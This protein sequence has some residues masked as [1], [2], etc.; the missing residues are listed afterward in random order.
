MKAAVISLGSTSSIW[1]SE[2]LRKHF[3]V[4][5]DLDLNE[6]EVA[7]GGKSGQVLYK[8]KPLQ[9]YDCI[10][11]RGSF[12]YAV[13]LR[14]ITTLLHKESY[15]P[16]RPSSF[17]IGHDKILTHLKFQEFNVPQP[18]TFVATTADNGKKSVKNLTFPVIMK[19]PAGTHGKGVLIADSEESANSMVDALSLL[20]QPFLIQQ[21]VETQGRDYRCLVVGEDIVAAM[22]RVAA[23]GESRANIHSGGRGEKI[24]LDEKTKKAAL[25]AAKSCGIDICAVD[26][27]PGVK[28][29]LVLEVNLSPGL[30]GITRVTGINVA[31]IIAKFLFDKTI[32]R[33]SKEGNELV[34]ELEPEQEV[35]GPLDFRGNKI[36]LSEVVSDA[37]KIG[38][39]DEVVVKARKGKIEIVSKGQ[40]KKSEE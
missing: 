37:S 13:L 23:K 40:K 4:V 30:Q 24:E 19:T 18:T 28:G 22:R 14:A 29:P 36:L 32:A 17:T 25:L 6:L 9:K 12:R 20:R 39:N 16:L 15:M 35:H 11:A 27:L 1:I 10:Y 38:E 31:E 33:R 26:I 21:Y 3:E 5:D 2:A 34:L 8:G 7:L